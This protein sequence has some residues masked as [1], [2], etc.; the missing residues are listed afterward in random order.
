VPRVINKRD[1]NPGDV[2]VYTPKA[3]GNRK[4][5]LEDR[6][7]VHYREPNDRDRRRLKFGGSAGTVRKFKDGTV[8]I[9]PDADSEVVRMERAVEG[10]VEKVENYIGPNGPITNGI[11]FAEYAEDVFFFEVARL[12]LDGM[13]VSDQEKKHSSG[14]LDSFCE[15]T[16]ALGGIA[17]RALS[18]GLTQPETAT[19]KTQDLST[20]QTEV[21]NS[22]DARSAG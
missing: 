13:D 6:V 16:Q 10:N 5:P 9:T 7:V 17:K 15:E 18:K 8:E 21:S 20:L 2:V 19:E 3:D 4:A 12:I 11:E 1:N 14:Q 22:T